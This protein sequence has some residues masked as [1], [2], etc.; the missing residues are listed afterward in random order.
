MG[1]AVHWTGCSPLPTEGQVGSAGVRLQTPGLT[2]QLQNLLL[3]QGDTLL[4]NVFSCQR[5]KLV[6]TPFIPA[7]IYSITVQNT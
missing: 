4:N 2:L 1:P 6:L 5:T 3:P 7:M